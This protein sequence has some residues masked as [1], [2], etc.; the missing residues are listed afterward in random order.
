M[1]VVCLTYGA[2]KQEISF[3]LGRVLLSNNCA[4]VIQGTQHISLTLTAVHI[5]GEECAEDV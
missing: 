2:A 1:A 5:M 3:A 4:H